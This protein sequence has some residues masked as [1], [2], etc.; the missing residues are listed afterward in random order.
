MIRDV[1]QQV[2]AER[3]AR[4]LAARGAVLG[5]GDDESPRRTRCAAEI[6]SIIVEQGGVVSAV[7]RIIEPETAASGDGRQLPDA[8]RLAG[9]NVTHRSTIDALSVQCVHRIATGHQ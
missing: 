5:G 3:R 7:V 4:H 1:T 9:A 6:C 8:G 2:A